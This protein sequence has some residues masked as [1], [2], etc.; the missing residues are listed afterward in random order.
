[1][2]KRGAITFV[3]PREEVVGLTYIF[4]GH[5]EGPENNFGSHE[6]GTDTF[7]ASGS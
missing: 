6:D 2:E 5:N 4:H 7:V 1:M 3:I